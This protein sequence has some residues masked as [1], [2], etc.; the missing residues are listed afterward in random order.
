MRV[1]QT[2]IRGHQSGGKDE[3][4]SVGVLIGAI[5]RFGL[6][7]LMLQTLKSLDMIWGNQNPLLG[8][9]LDPR[10]VVKGVSESKWHNLT[11][12]ASFL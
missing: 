6:N 7:L 8:N 5:N 4:T 9:S 10:E 12:G 2:L 3:G 1:V 11:W